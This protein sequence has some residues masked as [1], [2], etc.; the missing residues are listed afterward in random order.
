MSAPAENASAPSPRTTI[1]RTPGSSERA[2]TAWGSSSHMASVIA[3]SLSSWHSVRMPI[4]PRRSVRISAIAEGL[5]ERERN[6][7]RLV[8]P[9][10]PRHDLHGGGEAVVG[11]TARDRE[12]REAQERD[13]PARSHR[14]K[15]LGEV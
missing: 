7:D 14:L 8:V 5:L 10:G 1:A 4:A 15:A 3:F 9:E 13:A 6:S 12:R 2:V 11:A